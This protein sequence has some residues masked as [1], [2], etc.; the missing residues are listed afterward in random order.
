M[1]E[2]LLLIGLFLSSTNGIMAQEAYVYNVKLDKTSLELSTKNKQRIETKVLQILS[3][4]GYGANESELNSISIIPRFEILENREHQGLETMTFISADFSLL[5]RNEKTGVVYSSFS[6]TLKGSATN[7][8]QAQSN[9]INKL[10]YQSE[11][12]KEF[13]QEASQKIDRYYSD[14]CDDILQEAELYRSTHEYQKAFD[15]LLTIPRENACKQKVLS[16]ATELYNEFEAG[17]CEKIVVHI[18][19]L[20]AINDYARIEALL[21]KL[22]EGSICFEEV[23]MLL[24]KLDTEVREYEQIKRA[25]IASQLEAGQGMNSL[26]QI[27]NAFSLLVGIKLSE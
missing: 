24:S 3:H 1:K 11:A 2:L 16:Q 18:E 23:R 9:A 21:N 17:Q 13:I 4:Y 5:I 15:L 12:L 8:S 25:W 22:K 14:K 6:K 20:L 10:P 26:Q 7:L 27:V 19:Y